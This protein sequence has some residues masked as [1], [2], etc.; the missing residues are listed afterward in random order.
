MNGSEG[1]AE[2]R[3]GE[4]RRIDC[5]GEGKGELG[6]G[7]KLSKETGELR[8]GETCYVRDQEGY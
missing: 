6:R 5:K 8:R 4:G 1:R 3:A 7:E 2:K